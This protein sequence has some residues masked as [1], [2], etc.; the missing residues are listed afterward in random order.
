M[1]PRKAAAPP[2]EVPRPIDPRDSYLL[3]T[4][5]PKGRIDDIDAVRALT[6]KYR[7]SFAKMFGAVLLSAC[8]DATMFGFYSVQLEV[9]DE[10]DGRRAFLISSNGHMATAIHLFFPEPHGLP[11]GERC[12]DIDSVKRFVSSKGYSPIEFRPENEVFP[13]LRNITCDFGKKTPHTGVFAVNPTY[14]GVLSAAMKKLSYPKTSAVRVEPGHHHLDPIYMTA[15]KYELVEPTSRF[16]ESGSQV[17]DTINIQ[18][19]TIV[20]PMRLD[21]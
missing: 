4:R 21:L 6:E 7:A 15:P 13:S 3:N 1:S 9:L 18:L 11:V 17:H 12:L 5:N 2:A 8:G 16:D 19:M 10:L 20:M 14:F